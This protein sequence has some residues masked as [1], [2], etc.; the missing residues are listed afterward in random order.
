M[1]M[2]NDIAYYL[3]RKTTVYGEFV[4]NY[5]LYNVVAIRKDDE[6]DTLVTVVRS[7]QWGSNEFLFEP[8]IGEKLL[9]VSEAAALR[10]KHPGLKVIT[11]D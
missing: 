9:T 7:K 5:A 2:P 1:S 6:G 3:M 4:K 8:T 11:D 10:L